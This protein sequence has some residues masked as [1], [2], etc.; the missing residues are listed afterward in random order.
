M[1]AFDRDTRVQRLAPGRW[2]GEVSDAWNVGTIPNGGY[3]LALMMSAV[4]AELPH[5]DPLAV[6]AYYV[7]RATAGARVEIPV[8]VVAGGRT[9]STAAAALVEDGEERARLLATYTDLA[10]ARGP[11]SVTGSPPSLPS[12]EAC[13]SSPGGPVLMEVQKRFEYRLS[14]ATAGA[15][16]G[17]SAAQAEIGGWIRFAD[18]RQPDLHSLALFADAFMPAVLNLGRFGWIPTLQLTVY[19]RARPQPGWLLGWFRSRFVVDGYLE[20]DGELWDS[21]GK[22]VAMSRQLARVLT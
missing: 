9:T 10:A 7:R 8:E 1:H 12:P 3:L 2:Q 6:T 16:A 14:P 18:G 13:V 17:E 22:L 11:T 19:F 21:A 15:A 5:P 4:S 20:E